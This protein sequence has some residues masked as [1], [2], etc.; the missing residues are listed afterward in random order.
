MR[1]VLPPLV[2]AVPLA[3]VL[4]AAAARPAPSDAA[5]SA[6]GRCAVCHGVEKG[7]AAEI[8]PNLWGVAGAKAG[9]RPGFAYSAALK[10]SGIVWNARTLDAWLADD[11]KLAPGTTMPN[12]AVQPADRAVIIQYLLTLR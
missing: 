2:M 10:K 9:S 1:I 12:Q 6:F 4:A 3:A 5:P 7:D 11:Q 8:G